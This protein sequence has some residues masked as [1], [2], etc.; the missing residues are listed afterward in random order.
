MANE[1]TVSN[2]ALSYLGADPITSLEDNNTTAELIKTNYDTIRDAVLEERNWTFATKR[3]ASTTS[4]EPEFGMGFRHPVPEEYLKV[5]RLYR[6]VNSYDPNQ[7]R[8][9]VGWRREGQFIIAR[10]STVY[11]WGI[12]R[13]TNTNRFSAMF[14]EC[15]ATRIA[16]EIAIAVTENH[17]LMGHMWKLYA[18]KLTEAAAGDGSQGGSD[19]IQSNTLI[20][21]RAGR[22]GFL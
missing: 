12:E 11:M 10:E 7:W 2:K 22:G 15:L 16:A 6:E 18:G 3:H 20:D 9:S 17:T 14:I 4:D 19:V 1:I 21:A 5:T 8:P 13:I